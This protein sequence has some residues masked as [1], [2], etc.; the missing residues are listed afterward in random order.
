MRCL[1]TGS[2]GFVGSY[3][4]D[5]LRKNTDLEIIEAQGDL[6]QPLIDQGHFEYIINLAAKSSVPESIAKPLYVMTTNISIALNVLQYARKYPP[7]LFIQFSS[8]E[9]DDPQNPYGASKA[10][11]EQISAA[12][13]YTYGF[14]VA[15]VRSHNIIG[16]GQ[17]ESKF[18]PT[19]IRSI[20]AHEEVVLYA[21][22]RRIGHRTY[23]TIKNVSDALKHVIIFLPQDKF[24]CLKY[25]I[26][27]GEELSNLDLAMK[28]AT[29]LNRE[30]RFKVVEGDTVRPGYSSVLHG[31]KGYELASYGWVP[32][33]SL[34]EGLSWIK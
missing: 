10:A 30:L 9:A 25:N 20:K 23:N 15:I 13:A 6:T 19:L 4:V 22:N 2:T 24:T 27:G 8:V 18:L 1:V 33:E 17:D 28:V 16:S 32:P 7:K 14:P 29:K 31:G 34:E 12:Y 21:H 3:L 26:D 11:Q 5:Y